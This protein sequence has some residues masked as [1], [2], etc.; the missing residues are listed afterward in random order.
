MRLGIYSDAHFSKTSSIL[1]GRSAESGYSRRLD[2][3]VKSFEWMYRK[4]D[5]HG[6][7]LIINCG[8]MTSSETIASEE[9]SAIAK[10]LSF[11]RRVPEFHLLGNHEIKDSGRVY[12]S[13]DL[14]G[15]Y[16]HCR[17]IRDNTTIQLPGLRLVFIPYTAGAEAASD[18]QEKLLGIGDPCIVFS[19]L[20]Y[21]GEG[22]LSGNGFVSA[23]GID[24][25]TVLL[26]ANIRRIFNGHLHNPLEVG[27]YTQIGSLVGN[28]FG[29][30]Y[31]FSKPRIIIYDTDTDSSVSLPNP[32]AVLFQKIKADSMSDLRRKIAELGEGQRCVQAVCPLSLRERVS[33]YISAHASQYGIEE[34]R[35]KSE[36]VGNDPAEDEELGQK[37]EKVSDSRSV[38]D[39]LRLFTENTESLP[40]KMPAM[41]NFLDRYFAERKL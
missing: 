32:H 22:L 26:N 36:T 6:T 34:Y 27:R 38:Y 9:N 35:V 31:A 28:G 3:L 23:D 40:A 1:V 10:A 30:S 39:L 33:E 4:F 21:S 17:I 29:D 41:L 16:P 20:N 24:K 18:L 14:I 2:T 13:I 19:H 7:D 25:D 8:D 15:G 5:E 11:S 37:I 12:S